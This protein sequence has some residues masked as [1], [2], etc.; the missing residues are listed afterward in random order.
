MTTDTATR[1][2]RGYVA[3]RAGRIHYREMGEGPALLL[4]HQ[5]PSNGSQFGPSLPLLARGR[6]VIAVDTPGFGMSDAPAERPGD[7]AYYAETFVEVADALGLAEFDVLGHHTGATFA[8][9]VAATHP[10]RVRGSVFFGLLALKDEDRDF[11][12]NVLLKPYELDRAMDFVDTFVKPK[13]AD[14]VPGADGSQLQREL[15]AALQA[16]PAYWW[17]YDA[18]CRHDS[19][20]RLARLRG[21]V[22]FLNATEDDPLLVTAM[23]AAAPAVPGHVWTD[24]EGHP[25]F[26]FREPRA[27]TAA[28]D[29][30][31][32]GLR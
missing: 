27:Y 26:H 28:V 15:I 19:Y 11:W 3:T 20:D 4:L 2:V 5:T 23:R 30:F 14:I 9:E 6:R 29:A 22:L 12:A 1:E 31:L 21:R 10:E 8:L 7:A 17:A 25:A 13:V 32:G 18:V 16:G 24:V